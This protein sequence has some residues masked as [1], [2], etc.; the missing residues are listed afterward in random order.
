MGREVSWLLEHNI[1]F[2]RIEVSFLLGSDTTY[3][4]KGSVVAIR[5]QQ[6][7]SV[8]GKSPLH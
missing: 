5:A 7:I 3:H 4:R 2:S 1:M 8:D 6:Y